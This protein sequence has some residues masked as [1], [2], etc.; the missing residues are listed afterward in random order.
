MIRE[1]L[2][3]LLKRKHVKP[4]YTERVQGLIDAKLKSLLK[5]GKSQG[6]IDN[7]LEEYA[8][9]QGWVKE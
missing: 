4:G 2:Y 9:R 8:K 7:N 3:R 5:E 6:Y 1:W